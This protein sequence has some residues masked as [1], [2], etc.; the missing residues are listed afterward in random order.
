MRPGVLG[1]DFLLL[2][3][4]VVALESE[5]GTGL[6]DGAVVDSVASSSGAES[7]EGLAVELVGDGEDLEEEVVVTLG[8]VAPPVAHLSLGLVVLEEL[9]EMVS[10]LHFL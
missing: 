2:L 10:T 6:N 5:E 7:H 9:L 4:S 3:G 8:N 1:E